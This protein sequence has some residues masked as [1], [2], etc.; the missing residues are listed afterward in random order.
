MLRSI[1]QA[2]ARS[3]T[4]SIYLR[5]CCRYRTM[6]QTINS[7]QPRLGTCPSCARTGIKLTAAG[8]LYNHGPRA[9]HCPGVGGAPLC[10]G[11]PF[12]PMP[13]VPVVLSGPG[14]K[15]GSSSTQQISDAARA[16]DSSADSSLALSGAD[17]IAS[18]SAFNAANTSTDH[19]PIPTTDTTDPCTGVLSVMDVLEKVL[20][21]PA[22]P[23]IRWIPK[24]ARKACASVLTSVLTRVT[25]NS[26]DLHA[27]VDLL[28]FARF[29]LAVPMTSLHRPKAASDSVLVRCREFS[30]LSTEAR[31]DQLKLAPLQIPGRKSRSS[32]GPGSDDILAK[33]VARKLEEGNFKGAVNAISSEDT[34]AAFDIDTLEALK[35]K[36]PNPP[37]NRRQLQDPDTDLHP[38]ELDKP[39]ILHSVF[40]FPQGSAG[41]PDGLSPQ[42]LKDLVRV[43]GDDGQL[44]KALVGFVNLVGQGK[45]P[46]AVRPLFFGARLTA[47][48]KKGG[49]LR[50]IAVG[51]TLRRVVAKAVV[52][53]A[54]PRLQELFT[55][56]QLGV[57]VSRGIEVGIHSARSFISNLISG[58]VLVKL[59]FSNAFNSVRRDSILEAVAQH[60]PAI[61]AFTYSTYAKESRL[62]F[63]GATLASAEGVQ[64]G[65]PLGP[66][67][68]CLASLPLLSS[69]NAPLK[70]GYL[71]DFTLGGEALVVDGEVQRLR[72]AAVNL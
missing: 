55:P 61:H 2:S 34:V 22:P 39:S 30:T 50:P 29:V 13:R 31:L 67:L 33:R 16:P 56:V 26:E 48:V 40:S 54:T 36:H 1:V 32:A 60:I 6:S 28:L 45:V 70:F 9:S 15:V 38:L 14:A 51:L 4:T 7:S 52:A 44:A 10:P 8:L 43:D 47:F 72:A 53:Y 25:S 11:F 24:A 68:F 59:D 3:T 49:G 62:F 18:G 58:Q 19:T 23:I 64:Q 66:L 69:C 65:D 20:T 5:Q 41:G 17:F 27:W 71:D 57:G 42:H 37:V 21:V 46:V 35:S 63:G 12:Q